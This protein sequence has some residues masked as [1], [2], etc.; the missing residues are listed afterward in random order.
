MSDHD[1]GNKLYHK[2]CHRD[3]AMQLALPL[4]RQ[5]IA[6]FVVLLQKGRVTPELESE[7]AY[8]IWYSPTRLHGVTSIR[9][10]HETPDLFRD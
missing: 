1:A 9:P 3:K 8:R 7:A 6:L 2:K 5:I 4:G 10:K